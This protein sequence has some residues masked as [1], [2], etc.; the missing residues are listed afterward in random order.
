MT[1]PTSFIDTI[2]RFARLSALLDDPFGDRKQ[3]LS[4]AGLDEAAWAAL[5][6]RWSARMGEG[7]DRTL[8]QR[9]AEVYG[10][11]MREI[12]MGPQAGSGTASSRA[13][14]AAPAPP[15]NVDETLPI[16]QRSGSGAVM[17]FV[18]TP[19]VLRREDVEDT[20]EVPAGA[21]A[22][23]ITPFVSRG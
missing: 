13:S 5:L 17:P 4:D 8:G 10:K 14:G 6:L 20:L 12:T 3:I 18:S 23:P 22:Q 21:A 15:V 11:T 16:T 19:R 1:E 2:E 9:F 7:G